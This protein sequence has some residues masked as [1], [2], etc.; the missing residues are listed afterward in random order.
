MRRPLPLRLT[1]LVAGL[2]VASAA[3]ADGTRAAL[4]VEFRDDGKCAVKAGGEGIHAEM[5]YT[6]PAS[7][8]ASGEFRC[9]V[10]PLP[11]GRVVDVLVL[12]APG[13]RPAGAGTPPLTWSEQNGRWRGSGSFDAVPEVIVVP[14]YFGPAAVRARWRWRVGFVAGGLALAGLVVLATRRRGQNG[15]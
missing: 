4:S 12:L 3:L 14:D 8:R 1:A 13:A 5:T 2:F 6:P 10:P 15:P 11:G 7:S 9:A